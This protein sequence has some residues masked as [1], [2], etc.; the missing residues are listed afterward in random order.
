MSHGCA[1]GINL[2]PVAGSFPLLLFHAVCPVSLSCS[3]RIALWSCALNA[4][5]QNGFPM[6]LVLAGGVPPL[7]LL[8]LPLLPGCCHLGSMVAHDCHPCLGMT[9][10]ISVGWHPD[11]CVKGDDMYCALLWRLLQGFHWTEYKLI[12]F[13]DIL[14]ELGVVPLYTDCVLW[15]FVEVLQFFYWSQRYQATLVIQEVWE[16]EVELCGVP[17]EEMAD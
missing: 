12:V 11:Q 15:L 8:P 14:Q 9:Q 7:P 16:V 17:V 6:G 10:Y 4:G 13:P 2:T 5:S 1:S 3:L